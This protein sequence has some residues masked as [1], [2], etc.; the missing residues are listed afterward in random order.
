M[1]EKSGLN[2]RRCGGF[3]PITEVKEWV[4]CPNCGNSI[5]LNWSFRD[6]EPEGKAQQAKTKKDDD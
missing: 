6:P 2:C 4:S 1:N 5:R 3:I